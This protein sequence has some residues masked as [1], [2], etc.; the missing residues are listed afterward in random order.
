MKQ[1][2]SYRAGFALDITLGQTDNMRAEDEAS[3]SILIAAATP[4]LRIT[5]AKP[6]AW[7]RVMQKPDDPRIGPWKYTAEY[8]VLDQRV[9]DQAGEVIYFVVD[10]SERLRLVGQSMSRLNVRWKKAPMYDVTSRR[11][12]NKRTLFHTSSWPSIE[13]GLNANE[14]P[15]FTVKALFRDRLEPLC[16][17][18]RGSL[19]NT[20]SRTETHLHRLSYH[21]ETWVCGLDFHD[22]PLWNKQKVARS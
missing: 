12:L 8:T 9:W 19:A 15:P 3:L 20:L 18:A 10:E 11:P 7:C 22:Y 14:R 5:D 4:F 6:E 13:A 17:Q 1:H 16:K 2:P 21:V